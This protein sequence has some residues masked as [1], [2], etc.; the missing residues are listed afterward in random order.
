MTDLL[1]WA[2]FGL[3]YDLG[4]GVTQDNSIDFP[5]IFAMVCMWTE[6][7][8]VKG[9]TSFELINLNEWWWN[10]GCIYRSRT[11]AGVA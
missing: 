3:F 10:C 8:N 2:L 6:A 4:M 5:I 9:L 7:C 1:A 11:E